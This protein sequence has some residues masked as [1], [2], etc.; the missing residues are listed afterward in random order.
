MKIL[1]FVILEVQDYAE[2][3][4]VPGL[5]QESHIRK[6][7][8]SKERDLFPSSGKKVGRHMPRSAWQEE[9]GTPIHFL[10]SMHE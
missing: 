1:D 3:C 6:R 2:D 5:C 8:K 9:G 10:Y 4:L 7:T